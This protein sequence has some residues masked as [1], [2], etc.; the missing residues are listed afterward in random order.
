MKI[1]M[2]IILFLMLGIL[3][4]AFDGNLALRK[5][6]DREKFMAASSAWFDE[7]FENSKGLVGYVI[8]LD[9]LPGE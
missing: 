3:F 1:Y 7:L 6:T 4:I 9:W 8:G 5:E 2:A